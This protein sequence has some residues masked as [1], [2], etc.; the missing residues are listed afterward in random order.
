MTRRVVAYEWI[1]LDGVV[2]APSAPD[3]DRDGGFPHGGWHL[4]Y[5]DDLSRQW[6]IEGLQ[7][8]GAFLF[9]RRTYDNFAAHWP[10]V[11]G[12]ESVLAEPL[13]HKTKYVAS[14]TLTEPLTWKRAE[15]LGEDAVVAVAA[16][17]ETDGDDLHLIGSA[18]L[19][20]SLITHDL[21]DELQLM[22]DPVRLGSGKRLFP[23]DGNLRTF[24]LTGSQTTTTGA[25]LLSYRSS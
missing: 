13:N 18:A 17:K 16:L 5:F 3:E 19:A 21:V 10:H 2:Q 14:R 23:D 8:A 11:T 12:P 6:V 9:G 24:S 25:L 15:L 20:Q 1:S 22:V 4:R 7:R